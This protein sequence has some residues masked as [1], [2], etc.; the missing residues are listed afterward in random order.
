MK[1]TRRLRSTRSQ[2]AG[3]RHTALTERLQQGRA[4][5]VG[6]VSRPSE[7]R[8]QPVPVE[9][10]ERIRELAGRTVSVMPGAARLLGQPGGLD[11]G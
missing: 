1:R 4:R 6:A 7:G 5:T 2:G 3:R 10:E 9:P 8:L 11:D